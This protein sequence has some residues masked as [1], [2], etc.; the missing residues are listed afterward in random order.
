MINDKKPYRLILFDREDLKKAKLKKIN[1]TKFCRNKLH[2]LL[3]EYDFKD[4]V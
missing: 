3:L 1:V 4:D 2:E